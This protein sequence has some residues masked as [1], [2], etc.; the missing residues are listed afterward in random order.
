[1]V[2]SDGLLALMGELVIPV[3]RCLHS[4][5]SLG[6][7]LR[8][9]FALRR[10]GRA[11]SSGLA[12]AIGC[13]GGATG[14]RMLSKR[15]RGWFRFLRAVFLDMSPAFGPLGEVNWLKLPHAIAELHRCQ[16]PAARLRRH[17]RHTCDSSNLRNGGLTRGLD[18]AWTRILWQERF[19]RLS[20]FSPALLLNFVHPIGDSLNHFARGLRLCVALTHRFLV[21][22]ALVLFNDFDCFLL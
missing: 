14:F 11:L 22:L 17:S 16:L 19:N 2:S 1:M 13:P 7:G 8:L 9:C 12:W 20:S 10:A 18:F 15:A 5:T 4:S 6:S 21:P 3:S